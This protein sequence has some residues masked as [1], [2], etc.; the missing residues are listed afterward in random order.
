MKLPFDQFL[1]GVTYLPEE[2]LTTDIAKSLPSI[3]QGSDIIAR[4]SDY[5]SST[6]SQLNVT[7]INQCQESLSPTW[8]VKSWSDAQAL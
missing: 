8:N 4:F 5:L 1:E 3:K 7:V 2:V 6:L